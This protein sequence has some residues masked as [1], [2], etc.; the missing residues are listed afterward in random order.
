MQSAG[1]AEVSRS[2]LRSCRFRMMRC[3]DH[4]DRH[5]CQLDVAGTQHECGQCGDKA[6]MVGAGW[7]VSDGLEVSLYAS[8]LILNRFPSKQAPSEMKRLH[9]HAERLFAGECAQPTADRHRTHGVLPGRA[10]NSRPGGNAPR[11]VRFVR[12]AHTLQDDFANR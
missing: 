5:R 10:G 7:S 1:E 4:I 8:D 12:L 9:A 6:G 2:A 11:A 3:F